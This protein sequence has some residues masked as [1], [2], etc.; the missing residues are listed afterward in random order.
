[1]LHPADTTVNFCYIP[2]TMPFSRHPKEL[3]DLLQPPI[4]HDEITGVCILNQEA[5]K[6]ICEY[7]KNNHN[8]F[9]DLVGFKASPFYKL[10]WFKVIP[11]LLKVA[12]ADNQRH[13]TLNNPAMWELAFWQ[14]PQYRWFYKRAAGISPSLWEKFMFLTMRFISI[15]SW[16]KEDP[17]LLL[18]FSLLYLRKDNNLG[19]EGKL[20]F[21][22]MIR[23]IY[24]GGIYKNEVDMLK[25]KTKDLSVEYQSSHP[26]FKG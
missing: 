2:K 8:Q 4:S 12:K 6:K 16:K 10:N 24:V 21:D 1:V 25:H 11:A 3:Y 14:Q 17:N 23:K 13:D 22:M 19:F 18:Y 26:W 5:A 7:L 15:L 9:C 20:I